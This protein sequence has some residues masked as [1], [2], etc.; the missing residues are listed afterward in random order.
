MHKEIMR[1]DQ[2][3]QIHAI[4]QNSSKIKK[5]RFGGENAFLGEGRGC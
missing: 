2:N 4:K 3:G 5:F 1:K